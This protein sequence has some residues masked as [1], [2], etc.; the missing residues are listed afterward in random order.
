MRDIGFYPP[1]C[2][3]EQPDND[4]E[5]R[6]EGR[7]DTEPE[8]DERPP[9]SSEGRGDRARRSVP[10]HGGERRGETSSSST[11][12]HRP[13]SGSGDGEP[14][15]VTLRHTGGPS[16]RS[17]GIGCAVVLAVIA[18]LGFLTCVGLNHTA[19]TVMDAAEG[20]GTEIYAGARKATAQDQC[21]PEQ[22]V[23]ERTTFIERQ[24]APKEEP[25]ATS[26]PPS[27]PATTKRQGKDAPV[28]EMTIAEAHQKGICEVV[29]LEDGR[30][31]VIL[32]DTTF[33]LA[34]GEEIVRI[35][36]EESVDSSY[37]N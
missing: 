5:P 30:T 23:V 29:H 13:D 17:F 35:T 33:F 2:R 3:G 15:E 8:T 34:P 31:Q 10:G 28:R 9:F 36:V 7:E 21:C 11:P 25:A 26:T 16:L 22:E 18:L 19:G 27:T 1:E 24:K 14:S 37:I 20:D 32:P 12:P 6:E 4:Y